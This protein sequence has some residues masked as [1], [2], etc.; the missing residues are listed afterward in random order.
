MPSHRLAQHIRKNALFTLFCI[1]DVANIAATYCNAASVTSLNPNNAH[2]ARVVI[3]IASLLLVYL[4][5]LMLCC[6]FFLC[7]IL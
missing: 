1:Q 5:F 6:V 2:R 7:I 4:L 3:P